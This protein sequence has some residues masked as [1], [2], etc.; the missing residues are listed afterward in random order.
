MKPFSIWSI[1]FIIL[2]L[3]LFGL[4]WRIEVF[5][6]P[7]FLIGVISLVVGIVLSIIAYANKEAGKLKFVSL[8]CSFILLFLITWY[9]PF[10]VVRIM[11]WIKNIS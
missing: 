1:A 6:E 4:T 3:L 5:F 11:T 10:L 2:G 8:I 7:L 9:E